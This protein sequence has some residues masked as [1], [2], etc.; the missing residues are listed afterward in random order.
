MRTAPFGHVVLTDITEHKQIEEV[1]T[2]L[3]QCGVSDEWPGFF[4]ALAR[5]LGEQLAMDFVCI[6]RLEGDGLNAR[7]LA[8]W[9]DGK[10]EDNV[11]YA[12][13]D[14]PCGALVGKIGLLFS[15]RCA[16]SFPER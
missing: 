1:L 7:T 16:A 5:Y 6:D 3:A 9:C 13:K 4:E 8:A 10:F 11:V 14:T 12:L 2:F 15:R